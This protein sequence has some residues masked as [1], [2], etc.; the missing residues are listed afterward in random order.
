ML[1]RLPID[2]VRL[3]DDFA[4]EAHGLRLVC[5]ALFCAID[6]IRTV[7]VLGNDSRCPPLL[8]PTL[9]HLQL[10][11]VPSTIQRPPPVLTLPPTA[12]SL[13][14]SV[15][16][17]AILRLPPAWLR[18]LFAGAPRLDRVALCVHPLS[19]RPPVRLC[20]VMLRHVAAALPPLRTMAVA[21]SG[22][23]DAAVQALIRHTI[24]AGLEHL[25]LRS[26]ALGP[27]AVTTLAAALSHAEPA[28]QPRRCRRRA[29]VAWRRRSTC[30]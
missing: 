19:G 6:P 3:V 7:C 18:A 10:L 25:T 13:L 14:L 5:R 16:G 26:T 29:D 1:L 21:V 28:L 24:H 15:R 11:L 22:T 2:T 9:V 30:S 12:R 20:N 4:D 27:A 17:S 8:P 23:T